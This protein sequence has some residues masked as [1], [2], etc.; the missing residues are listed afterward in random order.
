MSR[1][2]AKQAMLAKVETTY[3]TDPVPT[4]AANAILAKRNPTFT[5]LES[6]MAERNMALPAFGVLGVVPGSAFGKLDFEVEI[7]GAGT[8]GGV[9]AYDALLQ[10]C[11][12][13]AANNVGVSE[14]YTPESA[15]FASATI[16]FNIDGVL[17]KLMG[18]RGTVSLE[19]TND[20][21]PFFKF[22]MTGIYSAPTD[23][24]LPTLTITAWQKPIA[25]NKVNTTLTLGGITVISDKFSLDVGNSVVAKSYVNTAQDVR[26][27]DRKCKSKISMEADTIAAHDW[28]TDA[29]NAAQKALLLT[30]GTVAGNKVLITANQ[31]QLGNPKYSDN[32]GI[33]ML[34]MDLH[35]LISAGNDEFTITVE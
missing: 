30:H 10:A 23:T 8:A 14:V 33:T 31:M 19:F 21:I 20:A 2:F 1:I 11:G 4:G 13:S 26:I 7:S 24:A 27:N 25:F 18:C 6:T 9:P 29:R 16:Y 35:P 12:F 32:A 3:G 34:D 28:F 15:N 22:A 17:H 5:P